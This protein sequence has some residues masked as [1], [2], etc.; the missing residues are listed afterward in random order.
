MYVFIALAMFG[1]PE[2]NV[3]IKGNFNRPIIPEDPHGAVTSWQ[4]FNRIEIVPRARARAA[5]IAN[6]NASKVASGDKFMYYYSDGPFFN[7]SSKHCPCVNGQTFYSSMFSIGS[8]DDYLSY[9]RT[10]YPAILMTN[11]IAQNNTRSY[12]SIGNCFQALVSK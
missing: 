12:Y 4:M 7:I 5:P 3:N 11:M 2:I 1:D 10:T 8:L 6:K 9:T